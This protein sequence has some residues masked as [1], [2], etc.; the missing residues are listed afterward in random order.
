MSGA[1]MIR[2][3]WRRARE[4]DEERILKR[5]WMVNAGEDGEAP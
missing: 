4:G 5:S 1:V 2:L 3:A